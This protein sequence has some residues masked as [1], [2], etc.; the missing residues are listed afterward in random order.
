MARAT[1]PPDEEF[2]GSP[3]DY[4]VER[5]DQRPSAPIT[6]QLVRVLR[7]LLLIVLACVSLALFWLVG[8]M[9]GLF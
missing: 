6:I 5:E 9:L 8:T 3:D 1:I 4:I 2:R 7:G